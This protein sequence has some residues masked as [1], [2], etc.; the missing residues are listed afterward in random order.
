MA[1]ILLLF[2]GMSISYYEVDARSKNLPDMQQSFTRSLNLKSILPTMNSDFECIGIY[3]QPAF[4]HRLL[5]NHKIQLN[6]TFSRYTMQTRLPFMEKTF[7][8]H[9]SNKGCPSG[10]VPIRMLKLRQEINY[11]F[12]ESQP[13]NFRQ[14]SRNPYQHFATLETTPSTTYH[15]ASAWIS[16]SDNLLVQGTQ[17][18]LSQIWLQNG[19]LSE[20]NSIQ[21]GVGVN[22]RVYGDDKPHLA[23]FW[24]GDNFK[25]TGCFDA[26][27]PGFVQVHPRITLGQTIEPSFTGGLD[28]KDY[29]AI[30][31]T[32]DSVSGHWWLHVEGSDGSEDVGYWPKEIFTHLRKGSSLIKFGGEAYGPPNIGSPPMGTGKLP[33]TSFPNS[34][35]FARLQIVDSKFRELDVNPIDMKSYC[36]TS[37][38]CYD[39]LYHGDQGAQFRQAFLFG[40]PGGQC[41]V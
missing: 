15:G 35:F 23:S 18:S 10:K 16:A 5:K 1:L 25:K 20:L 30:K 32:Q 8:I 9:N 41:G 17:Y 13:E 4:K 6:P 21:V 28:G 29:I 27:C 22:P 2:L 36:D 37:S 3:K 39:L 7:Q 34:G 12:S 40:G 11:N 24:T 33:K 31:V 14:Y 19:P 26:I 38:D